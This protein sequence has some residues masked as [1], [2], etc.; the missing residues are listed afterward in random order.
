MSYDVTL[1]D[2]KL[3]SDCGYIERAQT[4]DDARYVCRDVDLL[5]LHSTELVSGLG[6]WIKYHLNYNI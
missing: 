3:S 5:R 1:G 6:L 4:S 2:P